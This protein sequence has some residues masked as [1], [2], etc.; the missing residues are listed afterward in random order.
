MRHLLLAAIL[1][2]SPAYLLA[3]HAETTPHTATT[4]HTDTAAHATNTTGDHTATSGQ[5]ND[6][7]HGA[8]KA[9]HAEAHPTEDH[10]KGAHAPETYF[11]I[12]GWIL[13]LLNVI[14]FFGALIWLAGGPV[15]KAMAERREQIRLAAQDAASRRARADQMASEI[16]TRL[17][18]IEH[19]VAAIHERAQVEGERQKR[20]L[21]AAAEVEAQKILAA[22]RNEV[23]NRLKHA[24]H[25]LTEYAGQLAAER[26]EAILRE[27]ITD[28]DR[29]KLFHESVQELGR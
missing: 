24:R 26:A 8:E 20:D 18:Q 27:R 12:P 15:K 1:L 6:I 28:A 14:F 9:A 3:Q 16:Q 10:G 29:S 4:A 25:E 21:I 11:G 5:P 13:K 19:E 22:A 17:S 7:A 2:T 23:D